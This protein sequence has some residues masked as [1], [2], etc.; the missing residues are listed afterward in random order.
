MRNKII[1]WLET[2]EDNIESFMVLSA[3]I[4]TISIA[5]IWLWVYIVA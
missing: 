1:E 4:M 3:G 2:N 5:L